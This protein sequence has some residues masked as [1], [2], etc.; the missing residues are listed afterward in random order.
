MQVIRKS[1]RT[2][3]RHRTRNSTLFFS[4]NTPQQKLSNLQ[5]TFPN[6][7]THTHTVR[8]RQKDRRWCIH[9]HTFS[10]LFYI[11]TP[12]SP[13]TKKKKSYL[14]I[15][16]HYRSEIDSDSPFLSDP[17]TGLYQTYS[18]NSLYTTK[19]NIEN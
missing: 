1:F 12:F 4:S 19:H 14:L 6:I 7:H 10:I 3:I 9:T 15:V 17:R 13:L 8:V 2:V 5:T 16:N 11:N 18:A